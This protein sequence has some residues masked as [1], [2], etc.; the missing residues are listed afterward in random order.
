MQHVLFRL[1]H[2]LNE[3]VALLAAYQRHGLQFLRLRHLLPTFN[4]GGLFISFLL[5]PLDVQRELSGF[6]ALLLV[7][8]RRI[9]VILSFSE[10]RILSQEDYRRF[11]DLQR[12]VGELNA[13]G[14]L[15]KIVSTTDVSRAQLGAEVKLHGSRVLRI[16]F[17]HLRAQLLLRK[18]VGASDRRA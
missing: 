5:Q 9:R 10:V 3:A 12:L 4:I 8:L 18:L 7:P 1:R 15:Q 2:L 14:L 17:G 11:F 13:V 16:R 6:G